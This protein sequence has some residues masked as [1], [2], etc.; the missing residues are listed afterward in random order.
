MGNKTVDDYIAGLDG[1][2]KE[3]AQRL[4]SIVLDAAPDSQE[5][6]KWA[7][8]VYSFGGPFAYFKAFKNSVNFGF[9]RG[10]EME[11]PY[12]VLVGTG[13]KMRHVKISSIEDVDE[14]VLTDFVRQGVKLNREKGDPT[15]R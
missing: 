12:G 5:A 14:Q 1:W 6:I 10:A 11:D 2:K 4:R 7:Q 8:P 15:G 3:V 9:W 13:D